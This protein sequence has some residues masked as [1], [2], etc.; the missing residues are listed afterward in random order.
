MARFLSWVAALVIGLQVAG[1]YTD[2]GP[3][4]LAENPIVQPVV[5]THLQA[6]DRIK[7]TVYG[8][9]NLNGVY[10]VD[11]AGFISV[12]LAGNIR[13][14]G[15]TKQEIQRDIAAKYKSYLQE[16]NV[17]VDFVAFRPF[18]VM[19]EVFHP[20]EFPYRAGLD[21]VSAITT[22]GGLTYRADRSM[23]FIRHAGEAVWREYAN[24]PTVMI[25]P[26]DIIR[27]PERYF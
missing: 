11:P 10:D 22:A 12:P 6:G 24:V 1:C 23:V 7:V 8:E 20:G 25:A 18:Y 17:T 26:G 2:F 15:R 3:V 5:P 4:V 13:A 19:G 27:I 21:V 16:P 9:E 14:A